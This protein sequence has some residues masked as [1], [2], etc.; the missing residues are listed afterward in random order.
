MPLLLGITGVNEHFESVFN[1][2]LSNA[3]IMPFG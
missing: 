1:A 2:E 3:V